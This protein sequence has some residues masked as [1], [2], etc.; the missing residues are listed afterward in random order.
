MRLTGCTRDGETRL[1]AV[2]RTAGSRKR[3]RWPGR[4]PLRVLRRTHAPDPPRRRQG[5]RCVTI[6]LREREISAL[7]RRKRL[8]P[9]DRANLA[10]IRSG[11]YGFL[12]D[13]LE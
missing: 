8:S 1:L 9:D 11:L 5:L 6:E 10:A 2:R 3:A 12:D 7:I 4:G 13:Y